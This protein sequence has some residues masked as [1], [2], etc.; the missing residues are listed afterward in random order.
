MRVEIARLDNNVGRFA[1]EY[2]A[3]ELVLDD[4]GVV[5]AGA[6]KVSGH[7]RRTEDKVV[8]EGELAAIAEVECDRCLRPVEV[9]INSDFRLEYVT[10]DTYLSFDNVDLAPEDL[11]LSIFDGEFI[12]V[13]D[14]VREQL[15]L[16][17]P[18]HAVCRQNC[19]GFCPVCG[20]DRNVA[21]C[22]CNATEIDPRWMGLRDL[23]F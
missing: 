22:N 18:M 11:A 21:D 1:H 19:K 6:P 17:I 3:G 12:D 14:I 5:L 8:V 7:V 10:A 16:A 20:A 15:L 23:R 4:D 13:D 9:P 2:V